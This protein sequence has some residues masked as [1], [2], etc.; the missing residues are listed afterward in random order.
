VRDLVSTRIG[1]FDSIFTQAIELAESLIQREYVS[2]D[3]IAHRLR[4]LPRR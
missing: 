4:A 2:A 1:Q 3:G